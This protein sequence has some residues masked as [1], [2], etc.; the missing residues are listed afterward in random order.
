M[1]ELF[2]F[3]SR[4]AVPSMIVG[5]P[6]FGAARRIDVYSA[7]IEGAQEGLSLAA[8]ILPYVL[9]IFFAFSIFRS[10]GALEALARPLAPITGRLGLPT[11]LLALFLVRPLSGGASFGLLAEL[12]GRFGPD[13]FVGR[14][15]STVQGATDTTF[16]II[17]LY[18]GAVG[19]RRIR[20]TL[21]AGLLGDLAGFVAAVYFCRLLFSTSG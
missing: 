15:A 5:I 11:D 13:S 19:I 1:Q 17:T 7:F 2:T 16:Y 21:A 20:H 10:S 9:A 8:R 14:L 4:W 6:L 3:V 18:F 12:L